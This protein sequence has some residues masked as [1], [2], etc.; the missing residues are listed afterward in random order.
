[1][2]H[3]LFRSALRAALLTGGLFAGGLLNSSIAVPAAPA[4]NAD[5]P[6]AAIPL[7][8]PQKSG[9]KPLRDALAARATS[10]DFSGSPKDF[11][12]QELS[13]LLWA[14][15][16]V[17]RDDGRRTAPSALN[18]QDITIY[19]LTRRGAYAYDAAANAMQPVPADKPAGD[20]RELGARQAFAK[21]APLTLIFVSDFE[22]FSADAAANPAAA[23]EQRELA[24]FHS[25]SIAQ[26]VGLYAASEGWRGGVRMFLDKEK[27]GTALG[28]KKSQWIVAA[29]SLT[30]PE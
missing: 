5:A 27:L 13:N 15:Y 14:S 28:L 11:S 12:A 19:V 10:R 21:H 4:A 1:M 26:N 9:G 6:A 29:F 20:I 22:K 3:S 23:G 25:G 2:T 17:N 16:G 7:P 30:K 24:A 8:A 18:K